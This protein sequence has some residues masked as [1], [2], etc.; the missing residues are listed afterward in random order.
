MDNMIL[1]NGEHSKAVPVLGID[2]LVT[3]V[4]I[5]LLLAGEL[6]VGQ[7]GE[8]LQLFHEHHLRAT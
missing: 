8:G 5:M 2:L 3:E 7:T 4:D 1:T 6:L